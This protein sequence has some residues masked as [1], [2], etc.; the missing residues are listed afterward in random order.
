MDGLTVERIRRITFPLARRGYSKR[1]VDRFLERLADWL[2]TGQGDP[3][4]AELMR[5]EFARV[6]ERTSGIVAEAERAAAQIRREAEREARQ[7]VNRAR[8]E[9]AA[10]R[11]G[12]A[13]PPRRSRASKSPGRTTPRA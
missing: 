8:D 4:R 7:I 13:P 5:R 10:I 1:E 2:E 3:A 12:P 9:A 6:G 11:G